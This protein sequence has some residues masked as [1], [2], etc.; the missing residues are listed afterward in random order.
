MTA[1]T[2]MSKSVPGQSLQICGARGM[3][4]LHPIAMNRRNAKEGLGAYPAAP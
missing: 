4:A 1:I 2:A 3:S